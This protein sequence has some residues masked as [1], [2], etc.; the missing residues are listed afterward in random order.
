MAQSASC[1]PL[2]LNRKW[3]LPK[4][5]RTSVPRVLAGTTYDLVDLGNLGLENRDG[6][7]DRGLLGSRSDGGSS[8]SPGG[9]GSELL[10]GCEL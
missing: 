9:K 1:A 7:S 8:E 5:E 6:I 3:A 10:L 2:Y 4:Q